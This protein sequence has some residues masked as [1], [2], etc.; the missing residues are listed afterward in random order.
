MV[1]LLLPDFFVVVRLITQLF[2][3]L[4]E[5]RQLALFRFSVLF[6]RQLKGVA[7]LFCLGGNLLLTNPPGHFQLLAQRPGLLLQG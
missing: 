4:P 5:V 1:L 2:N 6:F 7:F 3:F